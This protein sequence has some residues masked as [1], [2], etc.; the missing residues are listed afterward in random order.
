LPTRARALEIRDLRID[1]RGSLV[2]SASVTDNLGNR[3]NLRAGEHRSER[4][5]GSSLILLGRRDTQAATIA[6]V[7]E[8]IEVIGY[9]LP[10]GVL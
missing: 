4:K 6:S 8:V 5:S 3:D 10:Q 2:W 9:K 7:T 1:S